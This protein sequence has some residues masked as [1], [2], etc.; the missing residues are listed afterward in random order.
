MKIEI[1]GTGCSNCKKLEA[2]VRIAVEKTGKNAEITKV[3]DMKEILS[4]GVMGLPALV[5]DGRIVSQGRV[6]SV[7]EIAKMVG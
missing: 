6:P 7:D 1:L 2:N 4:Y 3:T 5:I